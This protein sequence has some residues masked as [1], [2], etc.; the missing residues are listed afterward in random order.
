MQA[1]TRQLQYLHSDAPANSW[2]CYSFLFCAKGPDIVGGWKAG[3][4]SLE[5][6][7]R[8][9]DSQSYVKKLPAAESGRSKS[10]QNHHHEA[11]VRRAV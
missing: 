11:G 3:D 6:D 10:K 1:A 9:L 8:E 5:I 2:I 4:S 7:L